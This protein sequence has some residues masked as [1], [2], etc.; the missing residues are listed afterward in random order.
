MPTNVSFFKKTALSF[1][2]ILASG[3]AAASEPVTG[4]GK[5]SNPVS[6]GG[7]TPYIVAE[8]GPGGVPVFG[9]PN[10]N[11][12]C[13][14]VGKAFFGNAEYYRCWTVK[15]N[16]NGVG[17]GTD[18]VNASPDP[19]C[20]NVIDVTVT[21]ET[22]VSFNATPDGIGAAIIK[23]G[24]DANAYVYEPQSESDS[25][26]AS[27]INNS[28][29]PA[30]LSNIGGFCWNP[31][32]DGD[33]DGPSC[34]SGE[35]AWA[36]GARYVAK[37]N[38]ATFT[39]YTTS[40]V[41]LYAGQT[42]NSGTVTFSAPVDNVVTI[43]VTLNDGWRF[44]LNPVDYNENNEPIYD[45]NIKVQDYASTP[46]K[47]NPAPGLFSW[48]TFADGQVGTIEVPSNTLYGIHVDVEQEVA[49]PIVP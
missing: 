26:L 36:A 7:V 32:P 9:G 4:W 1:A 8:T 19:E 14:D 21:D 45:N 16:F 44:A 40:S 30:E 48:K 11:R 47:K 37:G 38:W 2:I 18:F 35:T 12:T 46:P 3:A 33:G 6:A 5:A 39:K 15:Q 17:F 25:G 28:G 41:M 49:C 42:M 20:N 10:P 34:Y 43:T 23:G 29:N 22:Y 13:N 27:P 31:V 24:P